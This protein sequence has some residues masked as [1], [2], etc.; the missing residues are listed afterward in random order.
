M[1]P[2][3]IY[4]SAF[5]GIAESA[6]ASAF[7]VLSG[8]PQK[9]LRKHSPAHFRRFPKST[10]VNGR[11]DRKPSSHPHPDTLHLL[12]ILVTPK[13]QNAAFSKGNF[14]NRSLNRNSESPM[15]IFKNLLMP[16]FLMGCFPGDFKREN[17][18]LRHLGKRPI[19]VGRR[20]I[21]EGKRPIN[22]NGQFLGTL[23]SWKMAPLKRP[24]KRSTQFATP[25]EKSQNTKF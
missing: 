21:K 5:W 17:S 13:R 18:P 2:P 22:A 9:A 23:P 14:L 10:P 3:A 19:K 11:R 25:E 6:P 1:I 20:P 4:R 15:A 7:G 16:L 24:I 8:N 12:I